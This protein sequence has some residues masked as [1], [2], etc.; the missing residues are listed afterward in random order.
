MKRMFTVAAGA[1]LLAAVG[2]APMALAQGAVPHPAH[3]HAG[4]CPAPGDVVAALT[5]IAQVAGE[6]AGLAS[7]LP[8]STS[9]TSV[10]L[11]LADILAA[12]HAIVVHDSADDMGT[13]IACGDIGG[14]VMDGQ[15]AVAL[16]D[17]GDSGA[18]GIALL[19]DGGDGTTTVSAYL[20]HERVDEMAAI[21]PVVLAD[22]TVTAATGTIKVGDPITF[23]VSNTGP[24]IHELVL[25]KAGDVDV[26]LGQADGTA[27]EIEDIEMGGIGELTYTF[28]EPG[29]YQLAC[30]IEGHFESGM[31]TT[32]EVTE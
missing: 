19:T 30:H 26:P 6:A 2:V 14:V 5:D 22:F 10:P 21:A 4:A 9:T 25:E 8:V 31:V 32:F 1:A 13:Y 7:A 3:I 24:S 27:A 15:L 18:S 23:A 17:L 16:G 29:T 20:T 11:A 12:D 28:S